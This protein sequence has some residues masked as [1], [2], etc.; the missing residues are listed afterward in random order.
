MNRA[1]K[2][3]LARQDE[4]VDTVVRE[5]GK[6]RSDA[7]SMEIF[8]AADSLCDYAKNARKLLRTR[9]ERVHGLM[10]I[11]KQLRIV[12]RPLGVIGIITP[13]NGIRDRG[14]H[15]CRQQPR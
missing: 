15:S 4:I 3:L 1:L 8:A 12:Y 11:A 5:T 13:W 9:K 2:V 7:M 6:A 10:G 14:R